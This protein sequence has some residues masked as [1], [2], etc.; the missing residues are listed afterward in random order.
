MRRTGVALLVALCLSPLAVASPVETSAVLDTVEVR[1]TAPV[2]EDVRA[3]ELDRHR[4]R[5]LTD[6]DALVPSLVVT[7]ANGVNSLTLR[8]IGSGA[9]H[10]GF[11]PRVGVYLDGLYVGDG[12]GLAVPLLGIE[13]VEV[14]RGPQATRWGRHASAGALHLTTLPPA[15]TAEATVR[16]GVGSRGS[17]WAAFHGSVPLSPTWTASA[18][19]AHRQRGAWNTT[20]SG[21]ELDGFTQDTARAGLR[22]SFDT[23]TLD[24]FVDASELHQTG[25]TGDPLTGFFDAPLPVGTPFDYST[26]PQADTRLGGGSVAWSQDLAG[27]LLTA[28]LGQRTA[29]QD[30]RGDIDY[31]AADLVNLRYRDSHRT[32][33][34]QLVWTSDLARPSRW[35]LGVE[36]E[37]QEGDSHRRLDIGR[38]TLTLIP[39]PGT[40]NL[41]PFGPAFGLTTGL[42]AEAF[43]S[44][45]ENARSVWA[46]WD[47]DWSERW[48]THAG[49]RVTQER[50][51]VGFDLDGSHSGALRL[52][53]LTGYTDRQRETFTSPALGVSYQVSPQWQVSA[54]RTTGFKSGGWNVDF[55]NQ[56]QAAAGF[57]FAPER[58]RQNE[59]SVRG[60]PGRWTIEGAVFEIHAN[61]YQV[62]QFVE[63]G[64]GLSALQ[65][66]NAARVRS[67]GADARVS[68]Q[69]NH[70]WRVGVNAAYLDARFASFPDGGGR[71]IA[72]DGKQLPEAPRRSAGLDVSWTPTA[73]WTVDVGAQH[74]SAMFSAATNL[75]RERLGARTVVDAAVT[76]APDNR[77]WSVR[78]WVDNAFN[79]HYLRFRGRDVFGH[80]VGKWAE[81]RT[82]G[83]EFRM[84]FG[85]DA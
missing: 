68:L 16:L 28:R 74:R 29:R 80:Q 41:V 4:V 26:K 39:A 30:R 76:W 69:P 79:E 37:Q 53:S 34:Q 82:V 24:V 35:T 21:D 49:L 36:A 1:A 45:D 60:T 33:L 73:E 59:L 67:R 56:A 14:W 6:L 47:H 72:L 3:A 15:P 7:Q 75:A 38:D 81:P 44:V 65:L 66:R 70:A 40:G 57:A 64:N 78:L 71:G 32:Q 22:G 48:S 27:G 50:S 43:A 85:P 11:S 10:I 20:A 77:D 12:I 19:A 51:R 46:L 84:D 55:L 63:L 83:V 13:A 52:A 25:A 8:G 18:S 2:V 54:H 42:G 9:R 17:E 62:F 58:S 31:S 23:G 61:D 5:T